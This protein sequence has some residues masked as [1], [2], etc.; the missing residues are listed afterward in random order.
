MAGGLSRQSEGP[1]G[2]EEVLCLWMVASALTLQRSRLLSV[3]FELCENPFYDLAFLK[4]L[5]CMWLLQQPGF[6]FKQK[7]D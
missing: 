4:L 1:G 2:A 6:V 3:L 7:P 5:L